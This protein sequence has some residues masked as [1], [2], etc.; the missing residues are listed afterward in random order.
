MYTRYPLVK[1]LILLVFGFF[2]STIV[3]YNYKKDNDKKVKNE[4]KNKAT[5]LRDKIQ[6][7]LNAYMQFSRTSSAF[8]HSS[9]TI[10]RDDWK[11]FVEGSKISKHLEGFQGVAYIKHVPDYFLQKHINRVKEEL[12]YNYS[13]FPK[14]EFKVYTP[15]VFIEPFVGRNLGAVGFNISSNSSMKRAIEKARDSNLVILTDKVTLIQEGSDN[16]Q[17]GIVM[18]SPIYKKNTFLQTIENRRKFITGWAAISL[19]M[20][21]LMDGVI[22][23]IDTELS[24][25][26]NLKIYDSD[27]TIEENLLFESNNKEY[28]N[29][30]LSNTLTLPIVFNDKS[31]TLQFF[32]LKKSFLA[33]FN[34]SIFFGGI[35]ISILLSLL[36]YSLLNTINIAKKMA[37][38]LTINVSD[39]N[40]ELVRANRLLNKS[41]S[42]LKI[43]KVKAEESDR[44]KSAFLANM[45][46]EIRTPMN[47]IMGFASLLNE[48]NL[49]GEKQRFYVN[50]IEKSSKRMLNIINDII[51][52]SKIES[53]QM[54]TNLK[55][56]N[57]NEYLEIVYNL[58]RVEAKEK[59]LTLLY[60]NGLPYNQAFIKT[61]QTKFYSIL[62]NLVKNAIKFTDKG[63]VEFGYI[64]KAGNLEFYVRD[65]GIGIKKERQKVIFERFIQADIEDIQ[66]RQG[67]GLGLSITKAFVELLNGKIWIESS[68]DVGSTFYFTH[69]CDYE[70]ED[71]NTNLKKVNLDKASGDIKKLKILIADDN[72]ESAILLKILLRNIVREIITAETGKDSVEICRNNKD[73]DL[74]LMDIQMP[75]L[76]GYEATHQIR[77]FNKNVVIIAQTAFGL[78][79]DREKALAA[80]CSDYISK[81]IQKDLLLSLIQKYFK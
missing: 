76:N 26:I 37:S 14:K 10:T 15:I 5:D 25:R 11:V 58:L 66:A 28:N 31:W 17:P 64:K 21:D 47:G 49:T 8:F 33:T 52:I 35:I 36:L 16:L 50:I 24:S 54:E 23:N 45:S 69:P 42:E 81:P 7:R 74:I 72:K 46:H 43:A 29:N 57:V 80:G 51:D 61:D 20:N 44:L 3:T 6:S 2:L 4:L 63:T 34:Y 41:L 68:K 9:D 75:E 19:R 13:V 22:S 78:S 30:S 67:A 65:T 1:S 79:G 40:E 59:G 32:Q 71:I 12:K 60:K 77:K 27:K 48:P 62:T 39:K 38:K 56:V 18:Y 53:G 70:E 73:L 55:D